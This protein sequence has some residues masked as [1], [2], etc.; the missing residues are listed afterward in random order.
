M[1]QPPLASLA[2]PRALKPG[3]RVAVLCVS[4]PVDPGALAAGLDALRFAGLEPVA[5]I[6]KPLELHRH[7]SAPT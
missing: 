4:S 5:N 7:V 1:S 3:D 6:A 2:R